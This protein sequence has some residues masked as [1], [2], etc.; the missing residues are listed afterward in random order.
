[1]ETGDIP[2]TTKLMYAAMTPFTFLMPA[3]TKVEEVEKAGW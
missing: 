2:L 3:S 1:M